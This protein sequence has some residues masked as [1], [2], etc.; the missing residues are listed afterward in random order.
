[1]VATVKSMKEDG[2]SN[3]EIGRRLGIAD[4]TVGSLLN[5][6]SEK[7]M[8]LARNTA[9][10]I[11]DRIN[12]KGMIDVG[13]GEERQLNISREKMEE[14]LYILQKEGYVVHKGRIPQ[15]TNPNQGSTQMVICPPGTPHADIFK[16]DKVSSLHEYVSHDDGETF[17]RF[18]YPKSMD[19]K[20][21]M[22]RYAEDGGI[23]KDGIIELR[24]NVPD[25]S[26]GESR[27]SQVRILVDNDRYLKGMAVYS[28]N[29][30]DGVDVIFNTNKTKDI[31]P[32]E[33]MKKIKDDPENPFGSSIK[34]GGQSYYIDE[35]GK[36]QLSLINK[37]ADEGDWSE[38]SNALPSQFLGKQSKAL[39]I[40]QL[41]LAKTEKEDEFQAIKELQNNTI[42]RKLLE[43]FANN[44]D[45]AAVY[46]KAAALPGQKYHVIIPVNTL[47]DTEVYAP[48]YEDGTKLALVRYPHGGTF[49]IP[50]LTVNNRH[51]AAKELIGPQSGDA[52]GITKAVADRLSGA[53]F[54]GDTV[55]CIPTHDPLG[56]VKISATE[57]LKGLEGFDPKMS[58]PYREGMKVMP[59]NSTQREMGIVSNLISD[60]TLVGASDEDLAKAVRHSMVVIDAE[61]HGL[62]YKKSEIE[63]NINALK[64]SIKFLMTKM[65]I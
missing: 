48:N 52:I 13:K 51:K 28:D 29:M 42:K 33:V 50:I 54:D 19:S 3:T 57:P 37:R 40:K 38:W 65:V 23:D 49:E 43:E 12:E 4:T 31:P 2:L 35:N 36:K 21:M 1:M 47:K 26:L 15:L 46:L 10:F 14:A 59:K 18:V 8:M 9:D 41:T 44:C 64:R 55:M 61:K 11:R 5:P 6:E 53:D 62:D 60:M 32:R 45:S 7:R 63:N 34:A 27:Y 58:Y 56:K 30:P 25:L 24:R 22:I 39:I 16:Y 17:D 20:R